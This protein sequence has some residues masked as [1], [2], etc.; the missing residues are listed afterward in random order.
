MKKLIDSYITENGR[1]PNANM[2][3]KFERLES[4]K[5]APEK[6]LGHI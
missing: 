1:Q 2:L 4:V 3:A 6:T 5:D